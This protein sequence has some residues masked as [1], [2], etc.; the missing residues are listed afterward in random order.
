M[1]VSL[2]KALDPD[3]RRI[4][5]TAKFK[6]DRAAVVDPYRS[7]TFNLNRETGILQLVPEVEVVGN[8]REAI[9]DILW[10]AHQNSKPSLKRGSLTDTVLLDMANQ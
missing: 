9:I 8:C 7:L 10:R 2:S 4:G 1:V 5:I 3:G 6:K